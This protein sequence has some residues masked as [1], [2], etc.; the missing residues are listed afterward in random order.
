MYI[1]NV[2]DSFSAA[3][4]LCGYEGACQNLHGH[5]WKVRLE[6]SCQKLDKIGLAMDFGILKRMLGSVLA[7]FDHSLLNDHPA[8][9]AQ[10]PSS[11]NLARYIYEQISAQLEDSD[12]KVAAVEVA[13]SEKS[14]LVYR[15]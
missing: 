12:A 2:S 15:P 14:A 5:N 6:V 4:R 9:K 3:H 13:E 11:E 7:E 8:F 1:S 10:N